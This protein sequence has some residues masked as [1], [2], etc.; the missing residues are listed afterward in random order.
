M[1][2]NTIYLIFC[3]DMVHHRDTMETPHATFDG[4]RERMEQIKEYWG[5]QGMTVSEGIR[6][7]L[8]VRKPGGEFFR[9]YYVVTR[10]I[11]K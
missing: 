9:H 5:V 11:L 6:G 2:G 3:R 4:T 10:T 7:N 8:D 1:I